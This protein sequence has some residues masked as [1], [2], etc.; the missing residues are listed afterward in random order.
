MDGRTLQQYYNLIF[1]L[2]YYHHYAISE[3]EALP[4]FELELYRDMIIDAKRKEK[5]AAEGMF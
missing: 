5:E 2:S 4:V 3:L 1:D